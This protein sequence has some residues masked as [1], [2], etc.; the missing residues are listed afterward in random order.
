MKRR[1]GRHFLGKK[2][3][4]QKIRDQ[5][6]RK[7]GTR[8]RWV[9]VVLRQR[10]NTCCQ[11]ALRYPEPSVR[12]RG[13]VTPWPAGP[14]TPKQHICKELGKKKAWGQR[15][16][17]APLLVRRRWRA[18]GIDRRLGHAVQRDGHCPRPSMATCTP[19]TPA[20]QLGPSSDADPG[21]VLPADYT[22]TAALWGWSPFLSCFPRRPEFRPTGGAAPCFR[23]APERCPQHQ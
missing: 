22:S 18:R 6:G 8:R 7:F 11:N 2:R 21:V 13:G 9:G 14:D 16:P 4:C 3:D 12:P 23:A 17:V 10:L 5:Q 15:G 1:C 20:Q 19:T